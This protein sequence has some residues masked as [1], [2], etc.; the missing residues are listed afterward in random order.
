MS[1]H[2]VGSLLAQTQIDTPDIAWSAI[3]PVVILMVGGLLLLTLRS[4]VPATFTGSYTLFTVVVAVVAGVSAVP[5]WDRVQDETEG[6]YTAIA[7]AV[8]V[9]GF[10]LF[11]TVV[12]CAAV[13][14]AALL[15]DGYS[16]REGMAGVELYVLMLL[17]AS[18]GVIMVSANDLIVLF[19]GLEILSI[20]V[21]VLAALQLRRIE[22][23]EAGI[24]Y[25]VL[26]AFTSAF[27]LYGVAM[28]YGATGTT[29][30]AGIR[31][32]LLE[33]ELL[34]E[35]LLLAGFALLLVGFGFKVAAV[36]FHAWTPD[37]YQGAPSPV[38]AFMASA[39]KVA[40]FAGLLRV[41]VTTFGV[42]D[43]TDDWTPVVYGLAVLSMLGGSLLA[44]VQ[45]DVKRM[46][47]YSSIAHA[48]FILV[49]VEAA[50]DDG[51]SA[52][53]FYLAAYT[54]MVI[55]SFGV[56]TLMGRRGDE[57]HALDDY[58]GLSRSRPVLAFV[59]SVFLLAQAG[60]PFTAGFFAKFYVIAAAVD[61]RS[62][63][64]AIVAVASAVV[65]A[66][67][68]LRVLVAMYLAEPPEADELGEL[69]RSVRI[70]WP[71]GIALAVTFAFT[72]VVGFVPGPVTDLAQDAVPLLAGG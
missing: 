22:S 61:A 15:A 9:D 43:Y 24:K 29:N 57:H 39:V 18:G 32:F 2:L 26:G 68:Y 10:S 6:P 66:V 8:N 23:L 28:V 64:L 69:R 44:I 11:L 45:T 70:P 17:S 36:P 27:L 41:F 42:G 25:F 55:G 35:G 54:F 12:I 71:A 47:A 46:L 34:G 72:V 4:L 19:L 13:A 58:R 49:G 51:T 33:T 30:L 52:A 60:V 59:F 5:L 37:V 7:G 21:Y 1:T 31:T 3:A 62:F 40:A 53:L 65:A 20:A 16:R 14:L 48:G 67:L 38:V 50:T 56:I 63:W